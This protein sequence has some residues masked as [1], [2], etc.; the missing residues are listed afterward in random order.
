HDLSHPG[1]VISR[2]FSKA[3]GLAGCRVGY[4]IAN[5]DIVALVNRFREP[6][7]LNL[8]AQH[9]AVAALDD[10]DW[11][12]ERVAETVA[13]RKKLETELDMMGMFGGACFGNFVLLR[14]SQCNEILRRLE[15]QGI[16]PRPLA[17]YG[18]P[19]YLRISVGLPEE[20]IEFL[21]ALKKIVEELGK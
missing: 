15:D 14:H 12:M 7:N 17:P 21:S 4:A 18:M 2:T 6:F 3:Y 8:L 16:I 11:V 9:A 5:P 13:E 10:R 19:E 20:N 1:L